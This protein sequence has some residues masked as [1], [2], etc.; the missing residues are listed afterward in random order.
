MRVLMPNAAQL[1]HEVECC[2][3]EIAWLQK[4]Q[5]VLELRKALLT[6]RSGM[7]TSRAESVDLGLVDRWV[8]ERGD[9]I[10]AV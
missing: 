7:E 9:D 1:D 8:A 3:E 10:V 5:L 6:C 2:G 4:G